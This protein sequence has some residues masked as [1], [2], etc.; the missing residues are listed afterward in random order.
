M[1]A[2][3]PSRRLF[4]GTVKTMNDRTTT[5]I[6]EYGQPIG[7]ALPGWSARALPP[8][9]PMQGRYCRVE[10]LD[11]ARHAADLFEVYAQAPDG[12]DWTYLTNGP[13]ADLAAYTAFATKAMASADP[14]HHAIIDLASGKAVGTAALMRIDPAN[15]VI[16]V[17]HVSYSRAL[18]RTPIATEA[19]YLF[20]QRV[21]DELGY[22]RY[23]WKCDSLNAP[24]RRA[25]ARYGFTFEG[26]F[27]QAIVYRGR[28]RDTAWY[29]IIDSEWPVLRKAYEQWLAPDNFDA[30]G[31]QRRKL[32]DFMEQA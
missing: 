9:T 24:S 11:A 26:I 13:Y 17:G 29:S 19:Q 4:T 3:A 23:E 1:L 10:P 15:G 8:R 6:N 27:R 5:R 20:M 22:R 32:A 31:V 30:A 7:P 16:E 2:T 14:M 12:S 25:A 28:S 18:K 21:F